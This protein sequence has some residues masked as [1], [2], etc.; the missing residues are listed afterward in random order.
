MVSGETNYWSSAGYKLLTAVL[1]KIQVFWD[2]MLL[3]LGKL[4]PI[5]DQSTFL[6]N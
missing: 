4:F 6:N 5:H 1:L 2:M 3:S